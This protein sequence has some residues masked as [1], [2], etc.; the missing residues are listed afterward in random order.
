MDVATQLE[1]RDKLA[2]AAAVGFALALYSSVVSLF[3]FLQPARPALTTAALAA[4]LLAFGRVARGQSFTW[5]GWRGLALIGLGVWAFLSA[6]WSFNPLISRHYGIEMLKLIAIYL[7]LVNVVNT[8]RRLELIVGAALLASLAPSI[9]TINFWRNGTDLVDGYRAHWLG[10]YLDP[11]HL[12]MS[13]VAIVPVAITFA[14]S[15]HAPW[16]RLLGAASAGLG[17]TA[18]ILSHSRG[19]TLGLALALGLWAL[20]GGKKLRAVLAAGLVVLGA[21]IFA[22]QTFWTRTET[23]STY[24]RDISAQGRVWAWEVTAAINRDRPLIG[25]GQGAFYWAWP[26]Y[27]RGEARH[28]RFVAHNV[29]LSALGELGFVGFF[30]FLGF[31]AATLAGGVRAWRHP[32]VGPLARPLTAG[33]AGYILCDMLSGYLLSA[34]FFFLTA[35]S[36]AAD[37][38]ARLDASPSAAPAPAPPPIALETAHES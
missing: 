3:P 17:I 22:P 8:P 35:L 2:F 30:L 5:D 33:F 27:A 16:V 10:V 18:I 25:V 38:A 32:L 6:S 28:A 4:L 15:R 31:V 24:E 34:H 36:A 11:N 12:A 9:G 21:A 14:L 29:F 7:T 19:G 37:R 23:I 1:K 13:L 26:E 20:T